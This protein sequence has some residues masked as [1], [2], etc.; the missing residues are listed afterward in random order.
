VSSVAFK[1]SI[2]EDVAGMVDTHPMF[3]INAKWMNRDAE[4][5]AELDAK[6]THRIEVQNKSDLAR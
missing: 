3:N 1:H 5:N 6:T 2:A 4:V